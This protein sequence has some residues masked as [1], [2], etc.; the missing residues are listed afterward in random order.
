VP[1]AVPETIGEGRDEGKQGSG[2][3]NAAGRACRSLWRAADWRGGVGTDWTHRVALHWR[4]EFA[5][6][7]LF[8]RKTLRAAVLILFVV[9]APAVAFGAVND[10]LTKG[11]IGATETLAGTAVMGMLYALVGGMPMVIIGS[12]G[13]LVIFT[14]LLYK[15]CAA[16]GIPFL[17]ARF[18]V[19]AWVLLFSLLAALFRLSTL[20]RFV[21]RFTDEIFSAHISGIFVIEAVSGLGKPFTAAGGTSREAA[22]L[23][24]VAGVGTCWFS[25]LLRSLR[26][27]RLM[28]AWV[29][30][31]LS[32]FS[33]ALAILVVSLLDR[34]LLQ[35]VETELVAAQA[36]RGP[37]ITTSGRAWL[38]D[39]M[40]LNGNEWVIWASALPALVGM[41]LIF[42]D[43]I[44]TWHVVNAPENKLERGPAVH[45]DTVVMGV[46]TLIAGTFGFPWVV[47]ADG[48]SVS[49]LHAL[50][51]KEELTAHGRVHEH[52][53]RVHEGR[54]SGLLVHAA[55]GLLALQ[56]MPVIHEIP[57]SVMYGFFLFCGIVSLGTNQFIERLQLFLTEPAL[58][59]PTHYVR[60]RSAAAPL[61]PLPPS[62][63]T[64]PPLT[65]ATTY[66]LPT[67]HGT[68]IRNV[69]IGQI[70][71]FTATQLL[72]LV[73]LI[74][75]KNSPAGLFFPVFILLLVPLRIYV[76]PH[77]IPEHY[78]ATLDQ[79]EEIEDHLE[80]GIDG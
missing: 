63:R 12:T 5:P 62:T 26:R 41:G 40:E 71:R 44:I 38:V 52:V 22:L 53:M 39:P 79:E 51:D 47:A 46:M 18:W 75:F 68:Q 7:M 48:R 4:A 45:Y 57:M 73:A 34:L 29:R 43:N 50:A 11:A 20:V 55:L 6:A 61:P 35:D 58:Y 80:Q 60:R 16:Y 33:N 65:P 17:A 19:S 67:C 49:H 15:A 23:G 78:L 59:P 76:L 77:I 21:T 42:L 2:T 37:L 8:H 56:G 27:G 1:S 64:T 24:L 70:N 32:D 36:E 14:G 69:P 66:A 54:W 13:P 72:L 9:V 31:L 28:R 30:E 25:L 3:S 10:K 74:M